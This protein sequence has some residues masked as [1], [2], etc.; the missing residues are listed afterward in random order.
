MLDISELLSR[1]KCF[2]LAPAGFGKTH[3][4]ADCVSKLST[5][6]KQL[7]LTHTHAGVAALKQKLHTLQIPANRV[8]VETI[9]GFAQ[10]YVLAFYNGTDMPSQDEASK[11]FSFVIGKA[12]ELVKIR[13]ISRA[14]A[15]S[16]SGLFVDEYQDCTLEQHEFIC[17]L[18]NFFPTRILG[19]YLQGIFDFSGQK[20]VNLTDEKHIGPFSKHKYQLFL[21]QRWL[22]GNNLSLGRDLMAIRECLDRNVS[23]NLKKYSSIELYLSKDA[24]KEH[25]YTILSLLTK[26]ESVLIID[27]L[28]ANINSRIDFVKKFKSIP[29][30]LEAIDDKEFYRTARVCDAMMEVNL[31]EQIFQLLCILFNKTGVQDWFSD[32]GCRRKNKEADKE[33]ITPIATCLDGLKKKGISFDLLAQLLEGVSR[34]QNVRC[35]RKEILSSLRKALIDAEARKISVVQSMTDQ[36]NRIRRMGR[37]VYGKCIGTT[38]LT[39]GLEFDTVV[40]INAQKFKCPKN[41]YVALTRASKRLVVFSSNSELS[42]YCD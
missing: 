15:S 38:L 24:I 17:A 36:R 4:I 35:Y 26:G 30:L 29:R 39:K 22:N 11:Y 19:D 9:S 32:K 3:L 41:L 34:L 33:A 16:Y 21:P 8:N 37:K 25:Y 18:S 5:S 14:V 28:S 10:K 20:L 13:P 42:P 7:I 27:P 12:I 6:S 40:I 23:I 1:D 2:V 31:D